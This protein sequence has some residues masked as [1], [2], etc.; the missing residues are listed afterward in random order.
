MYR[1]DNNMNG[2]DIEGVD[3]IEGEAGYIDMDAGGNIRINPTDSELLYV[4]GDLEVLGDISG[5]NKYFKIDHPL[6]PETKYLLHCSIEG[7]ERRTVYYGRV[8][9]VEGKAII[10]LPEWWS[11][12]NGTNK[13]EFNYQLTS[14]GKKINCWISK[15]IENNSFEI[16]S[17]ID[18][19]ICWQVTAVRHDTYSQENPFTLEVDKN[20]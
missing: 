8:E 3:R 10:S 19:T 16:S 17:D 12:L 18:G 4:S 15:E 13:E 14:I 5:S 6:Y 11:A 1:K 20:I 2:Y 9:T 7:P